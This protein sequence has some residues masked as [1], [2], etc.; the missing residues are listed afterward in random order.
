MTTL[1][2]ESPPAIAPVRKK[3]I[4][5]KLGFLGVGWI[6]KNRLEAI[7]GDSLAEIVAIADPSPGLAAQV[8]QSFPQTRVFNGL[9]ELLQADLDGVV[10]ATPSALHAD[11]AVN[12]FENGLAVF[13]QK[14]LGRN[15]EETRRVRGLPRLP[16]HLPPSSSPP[17]GE[18]LGEGIPPSLTREGG[19]GVR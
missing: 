19:Q 8:A 18:R 4:R 17:V 14:P 12:A 7:A 6:G 5:P 9:D 13:C 2:T 11:Q 16:P 1:L 3:I 15:A 10:I